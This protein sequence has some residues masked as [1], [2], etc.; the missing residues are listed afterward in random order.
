[1]LAHEMRY[2]PGMPLGLKDDAEEDLVGSDLHQDAID[3]TYEGLWLAGPEHGMP[4][5]VSRQLEVLMGT[6]GDKEDWRPSPDIMVHPTAGPDPRSSFDTRAEGV[7]PLLVEVASPAT[8]AY[9]L[10]GKRIGYG[11]AGVMEYLVF[12][13]TSDL[14]GT[15]VRAW[16]AT[17][18][19][20]V[21]WHP[22]HDGHWHS[23]TLGISFAAEGSLLRVFDAAGNRMPTFREQV[24]RIAERDRRIAELEAQLATLRQSRPNGNESAANGT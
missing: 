10:N 19:G 11:L 20:F 21:P 16:H 14:L 7:P 12:D 1:M 3:G 17:G 4:W 6:V 2:R 18:E 24:Q 9:D 8:C 22:A 23:R 5:H 15:P 13:P